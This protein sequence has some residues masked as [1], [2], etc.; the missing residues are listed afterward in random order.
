MERQ[1]P[2]QQAP[3]VRDQFRRRQSD[4]AEPRPRRR[5]ARRAV[6][7]D[8]G[9]GRVE[10]GHALRLQGGDDA[11]QHVA[12][13]RRGHA[14]VARFIAPDLVFRAADQGLR[15]LQHHAGAGE[16]LQAPQRR[17]SL[18]LHGGGRLAEQAGGLAGVRGDQ[19]GGGAGTQQGEQGIVPR[20]QVEGVGV[21]QHG[22]L[23]R[24]HCPQPFARGRGEAKDGLSALA[25]VDR[26]RPDLVCL[27][28]NMPGMSGIDV[29]K[30]IKVRCKSCRIVMISGDAS[31]TTVR[32]RAWSDS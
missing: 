16:S 15:A 8:A 21:E 32:E 18:G 6:Q 2:I 17:R 9:P 23:Q 29:L 26:V 7:P 1:A 19:A 24:Q 11:G 10:G 4:R 12:H 25:L 20:Q 5:V 27:D 14:G 22:M 31:M 13:A 3:R 30:A 28:V